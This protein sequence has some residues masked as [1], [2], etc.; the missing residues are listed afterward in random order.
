M[1]IAET[2]LLWHNQ[3]WHGYAFPMKHFEPAA[4]V[5]P[6]QVVLSALDGREIPL[7]LPNATSSPLDRHGECE[8]SEGV[9]EHTYYDYHVFGIDPGQPIASGSLH[10]DLRWFTFDELVAAPNVTSSTKAVARSL[11]EDRKVAV[12]VIPR[13]MPTGPEFL[14]VYNQNYGY[15]FPATRMKTDTL[16]AQAVVQ[17]LRNDLAYNGEIKIVDQAEVP[18]LQQS[19]RFRPRRGRFHFHL[20]LITFPDEVDLSAPGNALEESV[21]G[22]QAALAGRGAP[23]PPAP[24]WGWFT[25]DELRTRTDMSRSVETVLA[26]VLQLVER[27]R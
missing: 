7:D 2:F 18:S 6:A 19:Y 15:F 24:Y 25:A 5:D 17:A 11:V 16:P 12:A 23:A 22:L 13:T 27:N 4:G 26:T 9:H 10:P 21:N 14:L 1:G 8:F 3:R 20:C